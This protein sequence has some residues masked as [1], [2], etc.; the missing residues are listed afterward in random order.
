MKKNF[1]KVIIFFKSCNFLVVTWAVFFD[2][3]VGK[4]VILNQKCLG[5][6]RLTKV[7]GGAVIFFLKKTLQRQF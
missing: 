7:V 1:E 5:K 6:G 2:K 4:A 3:I